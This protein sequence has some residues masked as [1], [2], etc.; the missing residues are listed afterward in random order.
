V[1]FC[2]RGVVFFIATVEKGIQMDFVGAIKAGFK[3]YAVFTGTATRPEYWYWVLFTFLVNLVVSAI[4]STQTLQLVF[5]L[6][7]LL[8]SLAVTVRRLR[9]AGFSWTWIL[10]PVPAFA[11]FMYGLIILVNEFLVLGILEQVADNPEYLDE[12]VITSLMGNEVVIEASLILLFSGLVLL[13]SSLVVNVIFPIQRPKTFEQGNKRV[14]P[15]GPD[16]MGL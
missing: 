12:A 5:S 10:L 9:D 3:N 8:P 16:S 11:V 15:K 1:A 7:T 2:F 14:A 13:V 4:D 6:A